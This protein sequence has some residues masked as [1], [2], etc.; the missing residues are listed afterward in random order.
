MTPEVNLKSGLW[1]LE[2]IRFLW[3]IRMRNYIVQL[4]LVLWGKVFCLLHG[5]VSHQQ[6]QWFR[7]EDSSLDLCWVREVRSFLLYNELCYSPCPPP[8]HMAGG[9]KWCWQVKYISFVV[10]DSR[11][12]TKSFFLMYF[13]SWHMQLSGVCILYLT[14]KLFT[15]IYACDNMWVII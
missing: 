3:K 11:T 7:F 2:M 10:C 4:C 1:Y 9:T 8:A 12:N 6:D 13:Y 14:M 15:D 5:K